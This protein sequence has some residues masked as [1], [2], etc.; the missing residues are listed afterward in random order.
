MFQS[1]RPGA[2]KR[3]QYAMP[4][5]VM[6]GTTVESDVVEHT[7]YDVGNLP[8][9]PKERLESLASWRGLETF[10]TVEPIMKMRDPVAFARAIAETYP[11]FVNIGA[12]SK[13]TGLVEPTLDELM[14]F[15]NELA[16]CGVPIRRKTNLG[17]LLG[18][19]K[20]VDKRECVVV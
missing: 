18:V 10:V 2:L 7:V 20:A 17:R 12:D 9:T 1:K 5:D 19:S 15:L 6:V 11:R 4:E 8:E 16:V 14:A 3:L 13:G